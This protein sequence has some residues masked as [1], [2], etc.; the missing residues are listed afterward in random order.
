MIRRSFLKGAAAMPFG[1]SRAQG[2]NNPVTQLFQAGGTILDHNGLRIYS[3]KPGAGNLVLSDAAAAYSDRYGNQILTGLTIY[4]FG[5]P[6]VWR[7]T[8]ISDISTTPAITAYESSGGIEGNWVHGPSLTL[9]TDA[10]VAQ[11]INGAFASRGGSASNPSVIIT[12]T[13]TVV[14]PPVNWSAIDQGIRYK[15]SPDNSVRFQVAATIGAGAAAGTITLAN[16]VAPY[17]PANPFRGCAPGIFLNGAPA[18]N[19]WDSRLTVSTGGV[20]NMAGFPGGGVGG[21]TE[22]EG[23]WDF[24]LD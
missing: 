5:L 22:I 17:V 23:Q 3:P 18:N 7:A 21:V 12:D 24:P 1:T 4:Q 15:L 19:A 10:S 9:N 11:I 8:N 20:V 14:T 13:W 6:G 2:F 16:L